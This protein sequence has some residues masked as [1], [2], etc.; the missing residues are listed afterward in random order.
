MR[1][2]LTILA[3][4]V[5]AVLLAALA[6]PPLV[7][8]T[9]YRGAIDRGLTRALGQQ[10]R[11]EGPL[12]LRLLPTPR[13]RVRRLRL[14]RDGAGEASLDAAYM[15]AEIALTPLL[16][17][18]VRIL[19]ARVGRAEVK[20]PVGAGGDW[21][22]PARLVSEAAERKAWAL[23]ALRVEQF[24]L[25]TTEPTTGRTD[26][27]YVEDVR[28]EASSALGPWRLSG[29]SRGRPLDIAM[30]ELGQDRSATLKVGIGGGDT[31]RFD[32]DGQL[33]LMPA[34]GDVLQPRFGGVAKWSAGT[35]DFPVRAQTNLVV[36]GGTAELTEVVLEAGDGAA[37]LR[38]TGDGRYLIAEPRLALK[39]AGRR[40]DATALRGVV[41][42]PAAWSEGP[43]VALDLSLQLDA[44]AIG[45]DEDLS[46]LALA[47]SLDGTRG[48]LHS[49]EIGGPGRANL[50]ARGSFWLGGAPGGTGRLT[51]AAADGQRL[52]RSLEGLGLTGLAGLLQPR[53]LEA[54][55]EISLVDPV[56]SLRNLRVAQGDTRLFG[57]I[58]HSP[59][60]GGA[61]AR[62][63]AQLALEG[64]DVSTLPEA[65]PFF[66]LARGR[67]LGL[68]IDARDVSHG[69]RK[70]GRITGRILT[71]GTA[72]VVDDL[73]VRDLAGAE[74]RLSGRIAPDGGGRIEGTLSAPRAAP[75]LDL[76]GRAA[77]GGLSR[78]VPG[79][80]REG[81]VDLR[82]EV[83]RT[84]GTE[85]A[86]SAI[87][88]VLKGRL[89][90]AAFDGVMRT[91]AGVL[92]IFEMRTDADALLGLAPARSAPSFV[93]AG[94]RGRD[95]RL[96]A[97]ANGE[98]GGLALR[99]LAPIQFGE[100]DERL[101]A[102][103]ISIEGPDARP[104]LRRA[105]LDGAASD[106]LPVALKLTL[107][108]RQA[109][110]LAVTGEVAR[111][112]VAAELSGNSPTELTGTVSVDSLSLP[113]LVS[114]LA[115][116]PVAPAP[117]GTTW[118]TAR[119]GEVPALPFAGSVAVRATALDL[120]FG[121]TGRDAA[122][123]LA[124]APGT[125]RLSRF[126]L[127]LGE[128]RLRGEVG[129]E[130]QG[131]LAALSG[132]AAI[133]GAALPALLGAP[134]SAGR[135]TTRL[136]FG[137]SGESVAALVANLGG[138]GDVTLDGLR[139]DEAD[140]AAPA[141]VAL[142]VLKTDDPLASQ[143]WQPLLAEELARAP[144]IPLGTV[145]A[146][147]ALVG[148]ALRLSPLRID[149]EAGS[150]QGTATLDLRN[151]SLDARGALQ[152]KEPPRGWT[153][154]PP[155][156]GL[157]WT[158]PLGRVARAVD[159]APLV[160]GLATNVLTRELD[161]VDMFEQD[162]AEQRRRAAREEMERQRKAD[163][164]RRQR[165]PQVNPPPAPP[166]ASPSN[167]PNPGG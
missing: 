26:Q 3:G 12:D 40:V 98:V 64:L 84:G 83:E 145:T 49:I 167:P 135:M 11:T 138:A 8:W 24:L 140:A 87:Q 10:A 86:A 93:I 47:L 44:L 97:E 37:A 46:R 153:G 105:G 75:L 23:E 106:A 149:A 76:F 141:R 63:D 72:I 161:R 78:L 68:S 90:G 146:P 2:I 60:E 109:P 13:L 6:V 18:E 19:D 29:R 124:S 85:P 121:L 134:F 147:G 57:A 59:A 137:A 154:A 1:D 70:G 96:S 35:P 130:R 61:R 110:T 48:E 41:A 104:A 111:I 65:G 112:K 160:S 127:R 28:V 118:P 144:L 25:T 54:S 80:V 16:A 31:P 66:A 163:E 142:R 42:F 56:V 79:A 136:R 74:A 36:A 9:G 52:G 7:D 38:L 5:I 43:P 32:V 21:R 158:G 33:A 77:L 51:L 94:G 99:T 20:L 50:R 157:G 152:A 128:A 102:G 162:A 91:I 129:L 126:D 164:V 69:G 30:G 131:G 115:L 4:L 14:G 82:V 71:E 133:E 15:R 89:G 39:L 116:G 143:R 123:T 107:G 108:R 165:E 101:D 151:L 27:A 58:R 73:E 34:P 103:T 117:A 122:F 148:G 100:G 159:A 55:A 67:D 22:L 150:W 88:T 45:A 113:R 62:L 81:P 120:G 119:F 132:D 17:G 125:L 156:L 155:T 114:W 166:R 92:G 139:I 95:G 53:P